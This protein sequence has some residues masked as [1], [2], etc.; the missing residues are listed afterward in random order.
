MRL[1]W[2]YFVARSINAVIVL[3]IVVMILSFFLGITYDRERIVGSR[4]YVR[5]QT[6]QNYYELKNMSIEEREEWTKSRAEEFRV[7]DYSHKNFSYMRSKEVFSNS[8]IKESFEQAWE[9]IRLDFGRTNHVSVRDGEKGVT[10][11]VLSVILAYLP[12]TI[13]LYALAMAICIPLSVYIGAKSAM[14]EGKILGKFISVSNI[15]GSSIPIWWAAFIG[16]I[17]FIFGFEWYGFSPMPFPQSTGIDYYID[18]LK[19]MIFPVAVIVLIKLNHNAWTT[20]S[21]VTNE[22]EEDYVE[23]GRAKGLPEKVIVNKHALRSSAPPIISKSAHLIISGIPGLIIF[24][25]I[26]GWPG[27]GFLFYK[28]LDIGGSESIAVDINLLIGL[29]F[30]VA[31]LTVL[32]HL[33][34]DILYGLADPRVKING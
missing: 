5:V 23:A 25:G 29:T 31:L 12:R 34:A 11:E 1:N 4:Q 21:L 22:L 20:R 26:I 24:E 27:I 2:K 18:I 8:I 32:F 13:A 33:I 19:K 7:G 28:A 6:N 15:I 10:N 17:I 9:V 16:M 30:F 14:H 3:F